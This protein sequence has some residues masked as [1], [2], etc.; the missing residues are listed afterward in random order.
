MNK[1]IQ[2]KTIL[3]DQI[4]QNIEKNLNEDDRKKFKKLYDKI[5]PNEL[6]NIIKTI[7]IELC[8]QKHI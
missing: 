1:V 5:E 8:V 4:K 2:K 7:A 6:N 3:P